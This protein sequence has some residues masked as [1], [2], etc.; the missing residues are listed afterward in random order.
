MDLRSGIY[1]RF[2][3][4]GQTI[5]GIRFSIFIL[6]LIVGLAVSVN[7]SVLN[8]QLPDA[9]GSNA[10]VPNDDS[11]IEEESPSS[12]FSGSDEPFVSTV[13]LNARISQIVIPGSEIEA[14]PIV[15]RDQPVVVRVIETFP[16]GTDFRYDL[17]FYGLDSGEFNLSDYLRRKD[18]ASTAEIDKIMIRIDSLLGPGQVEPTELVSKQSRF[19]SYYL[20][21]LI[22]GSGLW[23]LGLL[24][25]LFYGRGKTRRP[26]EETKNVTVA[27]RLRPLVESAMSG[28]IQSEQQ[29]ELERVLSSFWSKKLRLNHL[30][31]SELRSKLRQH[32]EAGK[33]LDQIDIWLHKPKSNGKTANGESTIELTKLLEPYQS[34]EMEGA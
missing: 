3:H 22:V 11:A 9:T 30:P 23:L 20:P 18:Q 19:S 32:P 28:T 5:F 29:A 4:F 14:K 17:E 31:A 15:N 26:I 16:H 10:L 25:I 8:A 7:V 24:M 12:R 34:T 21:V 33:L 1:A 6:L 27:D 13:G 2:F